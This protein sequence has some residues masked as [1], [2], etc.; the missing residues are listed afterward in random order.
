MPSV[1]LATHVQTLV[2]SAIPVVLA[3]GFGALLVLRRRDRRRG[4]TSND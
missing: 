2:A 3:I 4:E 1:V